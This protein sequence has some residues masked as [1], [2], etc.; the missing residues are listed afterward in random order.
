MPSIPA[1][2]DAL[3][4]L[5]PKLIDLSLDRIEV[6]LERLGR[7][8]DRLP[9]VI[10][11]AGTNGKGSTLALLRA[12]LEAAG[13]KVHAYTS[14]HLVRFNE[15]I[16]LGHD[17]GGQIV[18]D[19]TLIEAIEKVRA[20]NDGDAI[21]Y[22]EITTAIALDLFTLHP[23]D[24]CLLEVG[25]GGRFD[26]TNVIDRPLASV[27]TPVSHDHPEFLGSDLAGIASE[28][29]GILKR[30]SVGVVAPQN[31]HAMAM[32]ALEAQAAG[33]RLF[34]HGEDWMVSSEGGRLVYQDDDGL[35]DLPL[36]RLVGH[37]QVINAGTAIA[38]LRAS[39]I[40]LS[41]AHMDYGL[42]H[43]RWPARLQN[44]RSGPLTTKLPTGAE[45]WLDG[46]HN[47]SAGIALAETM[48][49]LEE[50]NPRPLVL[51]AGLMTTKDPAGFF[52][53]FAGL[54]RHALM[55]PVP[56]TD[57]GYAPEDLAG[58]A[59]SVDL[60]AQ[61]MDNFEAACAELMQHSEGLPP[62]I[63]ICGSLY[64]AGAVL[65]D[66]DLTPT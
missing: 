58:A 14:P 9:P 39:G 32:I 24:Y 38:T 59:M 12:M 60:P 40:G 45:I 46:G 13:H 35:L 22:F 41:T 43:A 53:P 2:L 61:A 44:V 28:K 55:V 49:D 29:A 56:D 33:S 64:L 11:I 6:L 48:S 16:R 36:P 23:A 10:H 65:R 7:P 62:R 50:R 30:G 17:D 54:A 31:E 20:I 27:I 37:H 8:Q 1:S 63:L 5:H 21:T 4:A 15:R 66:N 26:A 52:A 51:I 25:L 57:A 18:G 34:R 42:T 19:A 47:Q 3:S